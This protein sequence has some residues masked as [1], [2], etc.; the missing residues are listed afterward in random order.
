MLKPYVRKEKKAGKVHLFV[1]LCAGPQL[2]RQKSFGEPG[3]TCIGPKRPVL[4]AFT[5]I[6]HWRWADPGKV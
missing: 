6:S 2:S 5:F 1:M 3:S 4:Y